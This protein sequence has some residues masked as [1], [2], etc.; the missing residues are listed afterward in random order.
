MNFVTDQTG[1]LLGDKGHQLLFAMN[2]TIFEMVL[3]GIK[4]S[5]FDQILLLKRKL[6]VERNVV[7]SSLL[8][9]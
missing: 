2:G 5:P 3:E 7:M 6:G 9:G 4:T 8:V 1:N